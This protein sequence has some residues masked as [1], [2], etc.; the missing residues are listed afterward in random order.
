MYKQWPCVFI[1][2][3]NLAEIATLIKI[4]FFS[5]AIYQT[6][7]CHNLLTMIKKTQT[8]CTAF[9]GKMSALHFGMIYFNFM[10]IKSYAIG[11]SYLCEEMVR[12]YSKFTPYK[13]KKFKNNSLKHF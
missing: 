4:F 6:M 3:A 12:K 8:M 11:K 13:R 7:C 2:S 10:Y 5:K 9:L 1:F